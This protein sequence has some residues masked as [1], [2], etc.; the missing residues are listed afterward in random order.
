MIGRTAAAAAVMTI[1][2]LACDS[3]PQAGELEIRLSSPDVD[4]RAIMFEVAA[5]EPFTI[6]GLTAACGGCEAFTRRV[7]D[8]RLRAVIVGPLGGGAVAMVSVSDMGTPSGY[9]LTVLDAAGPDL[10]LRS[11]SARSLSFAR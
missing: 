7:N 9:T 5:I 10:A 2:L 3:G 8:A 4:D 11:A 1:A 6:E